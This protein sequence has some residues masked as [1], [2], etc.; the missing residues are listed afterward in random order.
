MYNKPLDWTTDKLDWKQ[1]GLLAGRVITKHQKS[2][3]AIISAT[4]VCG[5][6]CLEELISE[7]KLS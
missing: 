1:L 5:H 3:E 4:F 6:Q 7:G 2:D